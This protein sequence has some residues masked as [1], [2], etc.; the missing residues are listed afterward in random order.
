MKNTCMNKKQQGMTLIELMI[1][2]AIGAFLLA[3]VMQIYLGSRQ[4]YRMLDSLSRMQ[5]NGRFAMEFISR[6]I[7]LAGFRE[8]WSGSIPTPINGTNNDGL[9]NS[10]SITI[11]MST[12]VCPVVVLPITYTIANGAGG[13][14]SLFQNNNGNNQELLEGIQEMQILYGADT[15]SDSTPDYYVPFGTAGLSMNQVVSIRVSLLLVS[16]NDSLAAQ[17]VPYTFNGAVI[18]PADR[19]LRRVFSSTVAIRN[20]LP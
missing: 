10:D 12:S 11:Q 3:G 2:L 4:S 1:A 7:R 16:L 9:N 6:D 20:L 19:R 5:E 8:C 13:A 14:P 15:N 18:T 17:P